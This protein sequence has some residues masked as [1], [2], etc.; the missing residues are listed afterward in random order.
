MEEPENAYN[1]WTDEDISQ[2]KA[3]CAKRFTLGHISNL[4]KRSHGA[5]SCRIIHL[6]LQHSEVC[7]WN[8]QEDAKLKHLYK[9]EYPINFIANSL[10]KS[11]T[12]IRNR[13]A[14]KKYKQLSVQPSVVVPEEPTQSY[15][16]ETKM[17]S[18]VL[19]D[20]EAN[21]PL[22]NVPTSYGVRITEMD[23]D[24]FIDAIKKTKDRIA[25]LESLGT[26]S[27]KVNA[28]IEKLKSSLDDLK[29]Q[30]DSAK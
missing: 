23:L 27:K 12:H 30:F 29:I 8:A 25:T 21:S 24:D 10:G 19:T 28:E 20:K 14:F 7:S 6:G 11:E 9:L 16:E 3:Y 4:L 2:L 1:P 26:D 17:P 15:K 22:V 18:I 5:I 13:I